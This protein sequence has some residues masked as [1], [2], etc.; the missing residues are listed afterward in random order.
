LYE[1]Q[2]LSEC[3]TNIDKIIVRIRDQDTVFLQFI[4]RSGL[5]PGA[6]VRIIE[7][8]TSADAVVMEVGES[9]VHLTLGMKAAEKIDVR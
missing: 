9:A 4:T 7:R 3:A 5:N 6:K 1:T 2:L 8:N